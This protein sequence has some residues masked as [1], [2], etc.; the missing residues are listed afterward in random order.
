[1]MQTIMKN[2]MAESKP[3]MAQRVADAASQ[4]Q[5]QQTGRA[6]KGATA[7]LSEDT[8]VITLHEALSPAER[9]LA[10][11]AEGAAQV[12][13]FHRRLFQ[14]SVDVLR[15]EIKRI[16]GVAVREAAVEVETSTGAVVQA[17]TTGTMVQVFQLAGAISVQSWNGTEPVGEA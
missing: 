1:M 15:E 2:T 3:T 6:P 11:N 7:V 14:S 10:Q 5:Q 9:A 16:T 12:Q 13:D 8:L 17:C 4:F